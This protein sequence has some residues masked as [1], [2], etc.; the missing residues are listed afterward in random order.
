MRHNISAFCSEFRGETEEVPQQTPPP[1]LLASQDNHD[2]IDDSSTSEKVSSFINTVVSAYKTFPCKRY[3]QD[4]IDRFR[5]LEVTPC[6]RLSTPGEAFIEIIGDMMEGKGVNNELKADSVVRAF[7][8][9]WPYQFEAVGE[10]RINISAIFELA[11]GL[12]AISA[13]GV[14]I[15]ESLYLGLVVS[16]CTMF[17]NSHAVNGGE[18]EDHDNLIQSA[19]RI[20]RGSAPAPMPAPPHAYAH[21]RGLGQF[22]K[23]VILAKV[24]LST[25]N[26]EAIATALGQVKRLVLACAFATVARILTP[27]EGKVEI[28]REVLRAAVHVVAVNVFDVFATQDEEESEA[29][30]VQQTPPELP[31][32]LEK[33]AEKVSDLCRAI[34]SVKE[35]DAR[36]AASEAPRDY[37]ENQHSEEASEPSSTLGLPSSLSRKDATLLRYMRQVFEKERDFP[38]SQNLDKELAWA[39]GM[40]RK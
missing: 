25:Q 13:P 29:M 12:S 15:H 23:V 39:S 17:S 7:K 30:E 37:E 35:Q 31:D 21:E 9:L 22:K 8:E 5:I 4:V 18:A 14:T 24:V 20:A 19:I 34:G 26:Q 27:T 1:S 32:D 33:L 38:G 28:F 40:D 6:E 10:D 16:F 36:N 2:Q 11:K 3:L